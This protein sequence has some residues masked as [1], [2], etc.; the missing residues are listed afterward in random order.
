MNK[1]TKIFKLRGQVQH[2]SWGGKTLIPSL[3]KLDNSEG[4]PFAEYWMGAHENAP[5][6][7]LN[8]D[9]EISLSEMIDADPRKL[10][11]ERALKEFGQFPYLFKVLDVNDMLSIQVHP[12]KT[13]A[14]LGF[15]QEEILKISRSAPERNYKDSNHKPEIMVALSDFWLLHGFK[16]PPLM[17]ELLRRIPEFESLLL[18][19]QRGGYRA[20]YE[21]IMMMP[22][23]EINILLDPLLKRILP[24]YQEGRLEKDQE[25]F[26]A[27]RAALTFNQPGKLDRGIISVYIFNLVHLKEGEGIFQDAGILHA[28][29]E[30]W[31][32]E[33][34]ASS[35]NVLRGG[36]TTKHINVPELLKHVRFEPVYPEIIQGVGD[37]NFKIYPSSARDFQLCRAE[38]HSGFPVSITTH[39]PEIFF[40]YKGAGVKFIGQNEELVIQA[41][42]SV[43]ILPS[44]EVQIFT[45]G[46]AIIYG[47][48]LPVKK[49]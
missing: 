43:L 17:E 36:L 10:L 32:M 12:S 45:E 1:D 19:F 16:S 9:K 26:W 13:A 22:Q 31:N 2:Y 29:L 42:E 23:Q 44:A 27:A 3:L 6:K 34:M 47:A 21:Y 14:E 41:G 5:A 38:P 4:K 20:L 15:E 24:A 35:D 11:G 28:Y 7:I 8:G 49:D 39:G 25:D 48:G 30:G 37:E 40:L 46:E 18:E 33:L